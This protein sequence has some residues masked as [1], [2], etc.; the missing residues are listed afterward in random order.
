[1]GDQTQPK[2][3]GC[4]NSWYLVG[5]PAIRKAGRILKTPGSAVVPLLQRFL[6]LFLELRVHL[7]LAPKK[8]TSQSHLHQTGGGWK[9]EE[10]RS[11]ADKKVGGVVWV[12]AVLCKEF[13]PIQA[14]P[15]SLISQLSKKESYLFLP[16]RLL[17]IFLFWWRPLQETRILSVG[18][19]LFQTFSYEK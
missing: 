1:M 11:N 10:K 5:A 3:L 16:Y 12:D 15:F 2:R 19:L 6:N 7:C 4:K 13:D 18:L 9:I 8:S 14:F 17:S